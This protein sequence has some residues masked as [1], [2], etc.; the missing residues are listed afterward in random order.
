MSDIYMTQEDETNEQLAKKVLEEEYGWS[1]HHTTATYWCD[2]IIMDGTKE[3]GYI[4]FKRRNHDYGYYSDIILSLNKMDTFS[5]LNGPF[6]FVVG[7]NDKLG[8]AEL[9]D[10]HIETATYGGLHH[11]PTM[12][13]HIPL[14]EF[15]IIR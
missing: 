9:N 3:V 1:L 11:D 4:E 5:E 2:L 7:W 14:E 6:Y 12:V 8:I 15:K 13:M 10:G